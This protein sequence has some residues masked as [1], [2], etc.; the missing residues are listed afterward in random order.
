MT[1][2]EASAVLT[3][4]RSMYADLSIEADALA[5]AI[6]A[7][8][9]LGEVAACDFIEKNWWAVADVAMPKALWDAVRRAGK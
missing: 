1:R 6:R 7:L 8:E 4:L 5:L 9:L 2:D 3:A